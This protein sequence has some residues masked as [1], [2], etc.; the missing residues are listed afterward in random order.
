MERINHTPRITVFILT[1]NRAQLV[2]RSIQSVLDH[3][4][5]AGSPYVVFCNCLYTK[6]L[7]HT[8]HLLWSAI[9]SNFIL[10]AYD[11]SEQLILK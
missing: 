9:A 2:R 11:A 10:G 6:R 5:S 1:Y 4:R 3:H 7:N 8:A